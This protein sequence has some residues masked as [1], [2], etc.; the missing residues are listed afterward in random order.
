MYTSDSLGSEPGG[1]VE[2]L[3]DYSVWALGHKK[4]WGVNPEA[5]TVRL[6]HEANHKGIPSK[7]L[8][9]GCRML[10]SSSSSFLFLFCDTGV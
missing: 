7:V 9:P 6:D 10:F 5:L 8:G 3:M 4:P 1:P 2:K